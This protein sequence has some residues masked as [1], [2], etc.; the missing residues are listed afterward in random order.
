M[1]YEEIREK[2]NKHPICVF[3]RGTK[4]E[5]KCKSS[6]QMIETLKKMEVNF[7]SY[8]ILE[9]IQLKEWLKFY[10]SW[11]Q[12]PMLFINSQFVGG[13]EFLVQMSDTQSLLSLI[14][15]DC[16]KVNPLDKIKQTSSASAVVLYMKGDRKTPKDGY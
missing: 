8:D 6:K 9:D 5:P 16:I 10:A 15:K 12:F 11:P 1:F 14:P 13:T 2:L 7:K 4:S 3:I